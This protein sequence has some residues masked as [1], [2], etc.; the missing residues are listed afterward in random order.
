M[1]ILD[2]QQYQ[3]GRFFSHEKEDQEYFDEAEVT[4]LQQLMRTMV[5]ANAK[6]NRLIEQRGR[7]TLQM[8]SEEFSSE[9]SRLVREF[10]DARQALVES[11]VISQESYS[12]TEKAIRSGIHYIYE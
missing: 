1:T 2:Q 8:T 6:I 3:D 5:E 9:W 11:G 12:L 4:H 7:R 10:E